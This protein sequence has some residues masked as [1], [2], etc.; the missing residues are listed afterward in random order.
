MS[1]KGPS[2]HCGP[3]QKVHL[4]VDLGASMAR[5]PLVDRDGAPIEVIEVMD[6]KEEEV[7]G[8]QTLFEI[9]EPVLSPRYDS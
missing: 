4:G 3:F 7:E 2:N 5:L 8:P 6:I 1:V 9:L